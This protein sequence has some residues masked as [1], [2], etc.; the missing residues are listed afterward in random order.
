MC[1]QHLHSNKKVGFQWGKIRPKNYIKVQNIKLWVLN[2]IY[3]IE[4]IQYEKGII[5]QNKWKSFKKLAIRILQKN[6]NETPKLNSNFFQTHSHI[7]E[8]N[9]S[10]HLQNQR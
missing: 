2:K 10:F 5:W 8:L 3:N 6:F 7:M 1:I 4:K 9:S